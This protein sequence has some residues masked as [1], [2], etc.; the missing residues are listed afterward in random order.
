[1]V[2]CITHTLSGIL[3]F[4]YEHLH[5]K[6]GNGTSRHKGYQRLRPKRTGHDGQLGIGKALNQDKQHPWLFSTGAFAGTQHDHVT[7]GIYCMM[8][9][10]ARELVHQLVMWW[11]QEQVGTI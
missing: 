11:K 7:I 9:S 6:L 10:W 4:G 3:N 1:M 2:S 8:R 5:W